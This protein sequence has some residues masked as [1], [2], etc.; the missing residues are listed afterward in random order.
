MVDGAVAEHA[1]EDAVAE[2][3]CLGDAAHQRDLAR[4]L[5]HVL[6]GQAEHR[7]GRIERHGACP[8]QVHLAGM[9]RAGRRD[10]EHA[11][12]AAGQRR[13]DRHLIETAEE[14]VMI[15]PLGPVVVEVGF[16]P[17]ELELGML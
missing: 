6:A 8:A 10:V 1:V 2:R 11:L 7:L 4:A 14:K 17:I 13:V 5:G 15:Q 3:Q 16:V 12:R 9:G